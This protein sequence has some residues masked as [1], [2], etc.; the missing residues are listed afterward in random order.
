MNRPESESASNAVPADQ[1]GDRPT[2]SSETR[3]GDAPAPPRESGEHPTALGGYRIEKLLGEGGMGAVYRAHDATLD[4]AVALKT[5]RQEIAAQ[6]GAVERFLREAR[7]VA[8]VRHDNVIEIWYIGEDA[9]APYIVMPLL[10]GEP[11]NEWLKREPVPP[12]GVTLKVGRE[13]ADGLEAAHARGLVHRDI[14]PANLWVEGDPASEDLAKQFRRVK[15]LYFGLARPANDDT[16]LTGTGAVLGTPAYMS[17]EQARGHAVDHRT[18]LFSLGI[19]LY[20]MTTGALPFTGATTMAVLT[21]LAVDEPPPPIM[22]N[23]DLPP[24]L[25]DL[26]VRLLSKDRAKRP[27]SAAEVAAALRDI[28]KQVAA[29]RKAAAVPLGSADNIPTAANVSQSL[30]VVVYPQPVPVAPVPSAF[31]ELEATD[32]PAPS[33]EAA[34]PRAKR[35]TRGAGL[36]V[37]LALVLAVVGTVAAIKFT[38]KKPDP[39]PEPGN[40]VKADPPK[41]DEKPIDKA[42]P[43]TPTPKIEP[44]GADDELAAKWVLSVGGKVRIK[45]A[46]GERDIKDPKGLPAGSF[47]VVAVDLNNCDKVRDTDLARLSRLAL[48]SLTM[49]NTKVGNDG[50]EHLRKMTSLTWLSLADTDITSAG[51]SHLN[52]LKLTGLT[53][54]GTKVTSDGLVHIAP[55]KELNTLSLNRTTVGD[56]GLSLLTGLSKLKVLYATDTLITDNGAREFSKAPRNCRVVRGDSDRAAALWAFSVGGKVTIHDGK[57]PNA[58]VN[59]VEDLPP[60]PIVLTKLDFTG[61]GA[62]V[63]DAGLAKLK[64]L[65]ALTFLNISGSPITDAG[66]VSLKDLTSLVTLDVKNTNIGD[67]GL[68]HLVGLNRLTVLKATNTQITGPGAQKLAKALPKCLITKNGG[69]IQPQGGDR[70]VVE[71]ALSVGGK[72]RVVGL[73]GLQIGDVKDLPAG[74]LVVQQIDFGAND[75]VT[76]DDLNRLD[77]LIGLSHFYLN[78]TTLTDAALAHFKNMKDL[79]ELGVTSPMITDAG[80]AHLAGLNLQTVFLGGTQVTDAGLAHLKNMGKMNTLRLEKTKITGPG[81]EH[82]QNLKALSH[83]IL[84]DTPL[85]DEG[86]KYLALLPRLELLDLKGTKVTAEGVAA[87]Q[88]ALPKCKIT[89]GTN[90]RAAAEWVFAADGKLRT[91][92]D[93]VDW[94]LSVPA[95]LARHPELVVVRV[96]LGLSKK[97]TDAGLVNLAAF[98]GLNTLFLNN[99]PATDAGLAHLKGLKGLT[100]LSLNNTAVTDEGLKHLYGLSNLRV[101]YASKVGTTAAGIAAL[102]KALPNCTIY[103]DGGVIEPKLTDNRAVAEWV[104]SVGGSVTIRTRDGSERQ[105]VNAKD[106]DKEWPVILLRIDLSGRKGATDAELARLGKLVD[107]RQLHLNA[108]PVTGAG[109]AHLK[110]LPKLANLYLSGAPVGDDGAAHLGAMPWLKHL[111]LSATQITDDG[112][113]HIGKLK[114]LTD[115]T[116]YGDKITNTGLAHLAWLTELERLVVSDTQVTDAGL[117]ALKRMTKL[118]YLSLKGPRITGTGLVHLKDA[119]LCELDLPYTALTATGLANLKEFTKLERLYMENA[120]VTDS[121]LAHVADLKELTV[122][123]LGGTKVTDDG[124]H[125][126]KAVPKL[127]F[128]NLERTAITDAGLDR[129]KELTGLT[130]LNLNESKATAAGVQKLKAALPKCAI[131]AGNLKP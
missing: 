126:L 46:T 128:L 18:D 77:G 117:V 56:A 123:R 7:A 93:G 80:L 39:A 92:K 53:F 94:Q 98:D 87:L 67:A 66:L 104:F 52:E 60:G 19:V 2:E 36:W 42:A 47:T 11:L 72:V 61:V 99:T 51:L 130:S 24:A 49:H 64:G 114:G 124:L 78:G 54:D 116:L 23:P 82:L 108:T 21:S 34:K 17:P 91:R 33:G 29:S 75:K 84:T 20:R 129:L 13:T 121:A 125:R 79:A 97:L 122:L 88:K 118:Q 8:K 27:A 59:R 1:T 58:N 57:T 30:P 55:Q 95:D 101:L 40:T 120:P 35:A 90:A 45:D 16:Q 5:M 22:L 50:L 12:L 26:I 81:L 25:S 38:Q 73:A 44:A 68:E 100:E 70:A 127:T 48:T 109:L 86:L 112:L 69:S 65:T 71:W 9:G 14:K 83:L 106:L 28:G 110:Q 102:A 63:N 119:P 6:P 115:L 85:T 32:L 105:T 111:D 4:R 41:K 62:S 43:P 96:D 74:P 113:Q 10:E 3:A 37:A 76:D 31:T 89:F 107:L 131:S 15:V 103:S